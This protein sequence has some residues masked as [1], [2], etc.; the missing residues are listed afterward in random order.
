MHLKHLSFVIVFVFL[1]ML[2]TAQECTLDVGGK[3][4]ETLIK[5]FQLDDEQV[6]K[7][8][9]WQAELQLETR[10]IEDQ[11][12][13]LFDEHPQS[14]AEQL[15]I[16]ADKY[17]VLQQKIVAASRA[18]DKMLL[19]IFN[20]KQYERYLGLCAEALRSPIKVTPVRVKD[21]IQGPE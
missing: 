3:N 4:A 13:K 9:A 21:S 2:G 8:E 15:T 20:E 17:R 7:M 5:V 14:T 19:S 11:I 16:M 18:T 1:P 6:A 12:Q 10:T